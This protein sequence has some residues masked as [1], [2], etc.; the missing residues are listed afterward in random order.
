MSDSLDRIAASLVVT[1]AYV[2][3]LYGAC[4]LLGID[5]ASW[6]MWAVGAA[7]WCFMWIYRALGP[8]PRQ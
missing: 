5:P 1:L 8:E 4:L 6:H 2:A 3:F 7:L